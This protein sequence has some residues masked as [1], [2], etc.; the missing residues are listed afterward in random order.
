MTSH[1][2]P[3]PATNTE[4]VRWAFARLNDHD[5]EP[6]RQFWNDDT[7]EYFPTGT[8]QGA[9][10]I[11]AYFQSVFDALE[12]FNLDV[13]TAI[14]EG[15]HVFVHWRLTGRHTGTFMGIAPTGKS[16][17]LQ[18]IDHFVI[19][20]G[21]VLSNTVRYDQMEFARQI[22][23]LPPDGSAADRALKAAFNG[24]TRTVGLI[25]RRQTG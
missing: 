15:E 5:V 19:R 7:L 6:L 20:D 23:L 11:A 18:G 8:V 4:L 2:P 13:V 9:D 1:A 17:D 22:G 24:K 25:R 3:S 10:G 14:G 16:L 12:G 21:V